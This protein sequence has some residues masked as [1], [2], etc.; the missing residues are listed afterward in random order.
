M[1]VFG[2]VIARIP[3]LFLGGV[4]VHLFGIL[5]AGAKRKMV[6]QPDRL[7]RKSR[8]PVSVANLDQIVA[9]RLLGAE[10]E[11][12]GAAIDDGILSLEIYHD[13]FVMNG[14]AG[15][16]YLLVEWRGKNLLTAL[17]GYAHAAFRVRLVQRDYLAGVSDTIGKNVGVVLA[18]EFYRVQNRTRYFR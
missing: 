12:A 6:H 16:R 5:F 2:I 13:K 14:D 11:I 8:H 10:R 15:N 3:R 4:Q 18:H 1:Q 17:T 7:D 9:I